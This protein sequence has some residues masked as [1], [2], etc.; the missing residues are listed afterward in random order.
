MLN[1]VIK[2]LGITKTHK[3]G[4]IVVIE[5]PRF[6][7]KAESKI[8]QSYGASVVGMTTVPEVS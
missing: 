6:S 4:S 1:S 7:S 8:W 5:G 2:D 3:E